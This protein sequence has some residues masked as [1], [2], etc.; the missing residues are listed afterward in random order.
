MSVDAVAQWL[1]CRTVN[2]NVCGLQQLPVVSALIPFEV[3]WLSLG[4]S[5][6]EPVDAWDEYCTLGY[7]IGMRYY[8]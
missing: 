5:S 1:G 2:R 6:C 3:N 7:D 8:E 4:S